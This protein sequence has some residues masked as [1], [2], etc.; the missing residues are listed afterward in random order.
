MS[1]AGFQAVGGF[2]SVVTCGG[3]WWIKLCTIAEFAL[4]IINKWP[5]RAARQAS[6]TCR[7]YLQ[8][9]A[10]DLLLDT[11][12]FSISYLLMAYVPFVYELLLTIFW[13]MIFFPI[14]LFSYKHLP[15]NIWHTIFFFTNFCLRPYAMQCFVL[16]HFL[17]NIFLRTFGI[18]AFGTA[19]KLLSRNL[20]TS[21]FVPY[22]P[23][24]KYAWEYL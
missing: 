1:G 14:W 4:P 3:W 9:F 20:L 12:F 18:W 21:L 24:R 5:L 10:Y 17:T 23:Q 2:M 7:V 11:I 8:T 22:L 19:F 16:N 15:V 13:H 6:I